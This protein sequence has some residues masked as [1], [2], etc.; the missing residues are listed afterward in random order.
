MELSDSDPASKNTL[1]GS[2]S[3][4]IRECLDKPK[5]WGIATTVPIT[6]PQGERTGGRITVLIGFIS[7]GQEVKFP[8]PD[9]QVDGKFYVKIKGGNPLP[10]DNGKTFQATVRLSVLGKI[11]GETKPQSNK[12]TNWD[13]TISFPY[14]SI[15][16]K[17]PIDRN[18]CLMLIIDLDT[19]RSS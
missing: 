5:Q 17:T 2:S 1:R 14:Y 4:D 11:I 19:E 3:I 8:D 7:S 13:E 10:D 16:V 15:D 9:Y 6:G 12:N 18:T